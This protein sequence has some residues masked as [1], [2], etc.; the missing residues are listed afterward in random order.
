[1]SAPS[2]LSILERFK[3]GYIQFIDEL[4]EQF[5]NEPDLIIIRVFFQNEVPVTSVA[6]SFIVNVLP[7]KEMIKK[8]DETF[9]LENNHMFG[10]LDGGKVSHFKKLWTS[11]RLDDDDKDTIWQWF[12]MFCALTEAYKNSAK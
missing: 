12:D 10:M 5:P 7:Y 4:L 2:S 3:R 8:R 1:M 11:E 6:E 9:F